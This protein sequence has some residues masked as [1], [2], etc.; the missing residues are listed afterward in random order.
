MAKNKNL[1]LNNELF[2][3]APADFQQRNSTAVNGAGQSKSLFGGRGNVRMS[4]QHG[5]DMIASFDGSESRYMHNKF[6]DS[7]MAQSTSGHG[8]LKGKSLGPIPGT[9]P[10]RQSYG[11]GYMASSRENSNER[12]ES[13][14]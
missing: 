3:F 12:R 11:G 8:R 6:I 2:D 1:R 9:A 13:L 10:S 4:G 7:T 5:N 14:F